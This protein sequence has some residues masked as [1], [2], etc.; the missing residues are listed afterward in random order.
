MLTVI[1]FQKKCVYAMTLLRTNSMIIFSARGV[2]VHTYHL[3]KNLTEL[4]VSCKVTSL[5]IKK[6]HL[7]VLT[8]N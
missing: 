2:A 8:K 7:R 6:C 3:V 4:G 1:T 5:E